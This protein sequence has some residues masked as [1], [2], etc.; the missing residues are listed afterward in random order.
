MSSMEGIKRAGALTAIAPLTWGS[1]YFVTRHFLPPDAPI[2]GAALRALPAG[3]ILLVLVRRPPSGSWWWRSVLLGLLNFGAFFLLVYL[4]AQLLPS[5]IAASL[6]AGA[7]FVLGGLGWLVLGRRPQRWFLPAAVVG[8]V[9][10]LL[11]VGRATGRIDAWGV[12]ASASASALV[13]SSLGAILATRWRSGVSVLASTCWQLIAAGLLLLL[14]AA[15]LEGPPPELTGA[16]IVA[17]AYVAV[18]A[19]AIAFLCWFSG[20]RRLPPGTIGLIGLL[21][22]VAGIAL[23]VGFANE[24]LSGW[25]LLGALLV[26]LAIAAAAG[27]AR[28]ASAGGA[29]MLMAGGRA[30]RVSDTRPVRSTSGRT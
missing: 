3:G 25:Q 18:I 6:M 4:S 2:W 29:S 14:A 5:S 10:V 24:T 23:G 7:P 1:T 28:R 13:C 22:P 12:A 26:I 8:L 17:Y 15:A 11:V 27:T 30:E 19:T 21:N 16:R 20:L 9:G